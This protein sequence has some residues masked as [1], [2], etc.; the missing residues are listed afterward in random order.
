ME[1]LLILSL[2]RPR[3]LAAEHM[4]GDGWVLTVTLYALP[5]LILFVK[6]KLPLETVR[7][8]APLFCRTTEPVNPLTVPL[9]L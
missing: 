7:S 3:L 4:N 9:T 2:A 5:L 6:L 1:T 8:S